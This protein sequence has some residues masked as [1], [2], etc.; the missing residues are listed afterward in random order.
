VEVISGA[1]TEVQIGM[2]PTIT[3]LAK[4]LTTLNRTFGQDDGAFKWNVRGKYRKYYV[5]QT[6]GPNAQL[7]R[8]FVFSG[9]VGM[10]YRVFVPG[11]SV[12]IPYCRAGVFVNPQLS[13]ALE[14]SA[15]GDGRKNPV[16][17]TF[18]G[19]PR[20]SG[21]VGGGLGLYVGERNVIRIDAD[22]RGSV[23]AQ[24]SGSLQ[25]PP[26]AA[27]FSYTIG[28]LTAGGQLKV[29]VLGQP[30]LTYSVTRTIWDGKS[31]EYPVDLSPLLN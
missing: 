29:L 27:R 23:G 7:S 20:L 3:S 18:S 5:D 4:V 24:G 12:T 8:E 14:M 9:G 21:S 31:D 15:T 30:L 19:G 1:A 22:I 16:Q 13:L 25:G 10:D 6:G 28:K 17:W 26:L 2:N 11:W